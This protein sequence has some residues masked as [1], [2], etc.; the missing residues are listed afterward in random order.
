MPDGE[1]WTDAQRQAWEY[2][3]AGY[4]DALTQSEA[5]AMYRSGE[6]HIRTADW[7][8]LWHRYSEG[9]EVWDTLHYYK[10][11]DTLPESFYM[12]TNIHYRN[13]Y[14]VSVK[15]NVTDLEGN[16]IHDVYR[17]IGSNERLTLGEWNNAITQALLDDPS[18]MVE[19]IDE[20]GDMEFYSTP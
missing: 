17:I 14:N 19:N 4:N 6:G 20:I 3:K 8:E 10:T 11:E 2:V 13:Q 7:G 12:E 9:S 5:L 18:I 16:K 1:L 15:V